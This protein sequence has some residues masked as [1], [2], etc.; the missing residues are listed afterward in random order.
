MK[1]QLMLA[2]AKGINRPKAKPKAKPAKARNKR[3][4]VQPPK[5]TVSIRKKKADAPEEKPKKAT[6]KRPVKKVTAKKKPAM[7][8]KKE[9]S[10]WWNKMSV[11]RQE[12]YLK[13]H[14]KSK[15]ADQIKA[16][17]KRAKKLGLR[18]S[19]VLAEVDVKAKRK[20]RPKQTDHYEPDS[21]SDVSEDVSEEFEEHVTEET[22]TRSKEQEARNAIN[23]ADGS[24]AEGV[25]PE[26]FDVDEEDMQEHGNS[27]SNMKE[28]VAGR[29]REKTRASRSTVRHG[30]SFFRKLGTGE[31]PTDKEYDTAKDLMKLVAIAAVAAVSSVTLGPVATM[32]VGG[33]FLE[34][35]TNLDVSD[36]GS[37]DRR[38]R[39][40]QE[41][42][43]LKD[44]RNQ[45]RERKEMEDIVDAYGQFIANTSPEEM[46]KW[47]NKDKQA[48]R[49]D[50]N[51]A[52]KR[53]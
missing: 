8:A 34:H 39:R 26:E 24:D 2:E 9:A 10:M 16:K 31:A 44:E 6:A 50:V 40:D 47:A 19:E 14:P 5:P 21:S 41:N 27:I 48:R 43:R 32:Y 52:P 38:A 53:N 12:A 18:P 46:K 33:K 15:Y 20:A 45:E 3:K 13:K 29:V 22:K 28:F 11:G 7:S 30:L 36:D 35:M 1:I 51:N 4:A 37:D 49:R 23:E 25:D 42:R 17:I